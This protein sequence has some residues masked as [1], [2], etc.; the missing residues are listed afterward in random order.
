VRR[1]YQVSFQPVPRFVRLGERANQRPAP[2]LPDELGDHGT[3]YCRAG[4]DVL[5]ECEML[6]DG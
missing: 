6:D 4:D 1:L 5:E 3:H 2:P